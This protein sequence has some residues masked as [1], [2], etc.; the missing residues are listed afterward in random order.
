MG[1]AGLMRTLNALCILIHLLKRP[2]GN[3]IRTQCLLEC[4]QAA[5][6]TCFGVEGLAACGRHDR[7]QQEPAWEEGIAWLPKGLRATSI[8]SLCQPASQPAVHET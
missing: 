1:K 5:K 6:C 4:G 3:G 2:T 7:G 8:G